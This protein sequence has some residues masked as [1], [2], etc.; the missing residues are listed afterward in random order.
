MPM[1]LPVLTAFGIDLTHFGIVLLSR[2]G[3]A[4]CLVG[5]SYPSVEWRTLMT[6][7]IACC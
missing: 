6:T 1:L 7:F 5:L 2:P 4:L 3:V